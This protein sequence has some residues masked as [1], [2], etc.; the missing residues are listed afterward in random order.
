M[1]NI[2]TYTQP[3]AN[4]ANTDDPATS[5]PDAQS[6]S[7]ANPPV[8][9]E[10]HALVF[11]AFDIGFQVDLDAAEPLVREATRRRVVRA[12]RPAPVWFDY[13]PPPLRLL[14]EGETVEVAGLQ[15][16]PAAEILIYDFGAALLTY[17][18]PLPPDLA[19][20]PRLGTSLYSH[21]GLEADARLRVARVLDAIRPVVER[22]RLAEA[23]EDYAVF[24]ITSWGDNS[25]PD[26]LETHR[27]VIAQA[28]EAERVTLS[29]AQILRATDATMTYAESDLAVIDWNAAV[30]F[31][32]EPDDVI[33]VLQHAN[34]ELLELRV[35]D[36]ELDA[37]LDH[38]DETLAALTSSRF[39][40]AFAS[41]GMLRRFASVQTDAAVMFE[42]VNN[43]IKLLGNQYL[44]RLYRV[45]ATRLDLPAWQASV[46]R[47]LEATE[48]LYQKM[49]DSTSTKRLEVLEWVIIILITV[50]IVLPFTPWY[51]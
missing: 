39:W 50:S 8:R 20:L 31:D 3:A 42:G 28:I 22:P 7:R 9:I 12:R 14:V 18:L 35:L 36:H 17:R 44:A 41:S 40:P 2:P 29:K 26:I 19:E 46:Q 34:I 25:P 13:S 33:S 30:L 47:K 10:G 51:H 49:S 1:P 24:A 45:A 11:F 4:D 15:T 27:A 21:A 16:D 48:S 23:V 43:A 37:I 38:A 5:A 32:A 6:A